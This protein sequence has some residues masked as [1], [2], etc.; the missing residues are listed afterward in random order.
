[1]TALSLTAQD[2]RAAIERRMKETIDEMVSAFDRHLEDSAASTKQHFRWMK[3]RYREK[4]DINRAASRIELKV[5]GQ[6]GSKQCLH[7]KGR[8]DFR[9][10]VGSLFADEM[11]LRSDPPM[12]VTPR[13]LLSADDNRTQFFWTSVSLRIKRRRFVISTR[14][15]LVA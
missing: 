10:V 14:K 11:W 5:G 6:P 12:I 8:L 3:R 15:R 4:I 2:Q 9:R 13:S 7:H 1:M